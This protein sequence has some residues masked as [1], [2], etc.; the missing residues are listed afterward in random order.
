MT[1]FPLA[2]PSEPRAPWLRTWIFGYGS[3]ISASGVNG[4]SMRR[5]YRE[6]DITECSLTDYKRSFCA[7]NPGGFDWETLETWPDI[8]Y[9]GITHEAGAKT[10]GVIFEI[11]ANDWWPFKISE[12]GDRLYWFRDVSEGIVLP[13]GVHLPKG[14]RVLTCV[15]KEPS[16]DGVVTQRYI[17]RCKAALSYRSPAFRAEF[18]EVEDYLT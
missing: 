14:A 9:F 8:R 7:V 10:N 13:K 18:G 2:L 3:L 11:S 17:D 4:R 5:I 16:T 15:A 6:P 1:T 12:G